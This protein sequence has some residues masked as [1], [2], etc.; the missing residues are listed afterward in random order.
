MSEEYQTQ[1][2]QA[3]SSSSINEIEIM[4]RNLKNHRGRQSGVG[5]TLSKSASRRLEDGATSTLQDHRDAQISE[6][7]ANH[8]LILSA[9]RHFILGFQLPSHASGSD[10]PSM[11][12]ANQPD[13]RHND[14]DDDDQN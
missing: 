12:S 2:E 10:V 11:S 3:G 8:E 9:L 1:L 5:P 13:E 7:R 14:N 6:L 4:N